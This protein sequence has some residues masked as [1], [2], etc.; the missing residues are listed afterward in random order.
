MRRYLRRSGNATRQEG[1]WPKVT[2]SMRPPRRPPQLRSGTVISVEGQ[3][4]NDT[5]GE[6]PPQPTNREDDEDQAY[7]GIIDETPQP[8]PWKK[9]PMENNDPHRQNRSIIRITRVMC[10]YGNIRQSMI[11]VGSLQNTTAR[12]DTRNDESSETG[13]QST[14]WGECTQNKVTNTHIS[15]R[16][17]AKSNSNKCNE[18]ARY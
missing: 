17:G 1:E 16:D 13:I 3:V 12:T 5:I 9:T 2:A 14:Q 10:P 18:T 7:N 4:H 15:A 8:Q 6:I 11:S